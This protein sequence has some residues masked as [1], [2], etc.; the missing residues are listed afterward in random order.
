MDEHTCELMNELIKQLIS[1]SVCFV[2]MHVLIY[3]DVT[4]NVLELQKKLTF[5]D[6]QVS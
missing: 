1:C 3:F 2:L 4:K 5:E 6:F